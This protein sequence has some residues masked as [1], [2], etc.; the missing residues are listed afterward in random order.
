MSI[1]VMCDHIPDCA[2]K[3]DENCGLYIEKHLKYTSLKTKKDVA[4]IHP[5]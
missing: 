1:S 4:T 5:L 3:E 2:N